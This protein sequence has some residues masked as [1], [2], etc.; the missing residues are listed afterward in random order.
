GTAVIQGPLARLDSRFVEQLAS[1][2]VRQG[3]GALDR[4]LAPAMARATAA[5]APLTRSSTEVAE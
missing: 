2:L 4:H 5:R 1:S 3:L